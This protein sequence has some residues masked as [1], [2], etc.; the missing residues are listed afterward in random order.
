MAKCKRYDICGLNA[1]ADSEGLCILHSANPDKDKKAFAEEFE[2]HR[3]RRG[4]NFSYFVF[5]ERI[6][7]RETKFTEGARFLWARFT[8]G[9]DFRRAAFIRG[10]PSVRPRSSKEPT[11]ERPGSP[12]KPTF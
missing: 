6:D 3:K 7:F 4:D 12:R 10:G 5:P 1:D 2:E 9:A 8:A 11:L